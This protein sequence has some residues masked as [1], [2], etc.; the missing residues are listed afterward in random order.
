MLFVDT[1]KAFPT[2]W[3]DGMF[4]RLWQAGVRGKMFRVLHNLYD[5]ARRVVSHEGCTTD[6]F[7]CDLGLHE[8]DVISPTLYLFFIDGLLREVGARHPGVT[9]LSPTGTTVS[10]VVGAMQADDFVAV[11]D[12]LDQV[13]AVANTV[14]AYSCKWRFRLN[15]AKSAVMHVS[16]TG[17]SQLSESGAE[18][19]L[20][21]L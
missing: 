1:F 8:G 14:Y 17:H 16:A 3:L 12:T 15:S 11:C 19:Q 6:S 10:A 18:G 21:N 5:G 9:L 2:V 20:G 7:T 13:Q 4:A